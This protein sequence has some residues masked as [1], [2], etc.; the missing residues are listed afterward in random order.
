[1]SSWGGVFGYGYKGVF[2]GEK[3][4]RPSFKKERDQGDLGKGKKGSEKQ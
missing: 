2:E 1:V 3:E 4:K